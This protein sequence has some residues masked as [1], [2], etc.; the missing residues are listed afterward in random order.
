MCVCRIAFWPY[1]F[2]FLS[3]SLVSSFFDN[4]RISGIVVAFERVVV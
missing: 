1:F 3:L 2:L 4:H